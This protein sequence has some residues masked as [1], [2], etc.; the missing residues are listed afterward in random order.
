[1]FLSILTLEADEFLPWVIFLVRPVGHAPRG[2]GTEPGDRRVRRQAVLRELDQRTAAVNKL[3]LLLGVRAV[4]K[5]VHHLPGLLGGRHPSLL[6]ESTNLF[7]G[8]GILLFT[9]VELMVWLIVIN[10][11]IYW[12]R[13]M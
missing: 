7:G 3:G 11:N 1:M 4:E 13:S 2:E 12:G 6:D 5:G 8:L 9:T 10:V